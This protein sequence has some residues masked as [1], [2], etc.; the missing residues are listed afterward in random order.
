MAQTAGTRPAVPQR[1]P[2]RDPAAQVARPADL[3]Q[4]PA[5]LG[6]LRDPGDPAHPQLGGLAYLTL[7][8][9]IGLAVAVLLTV[10]VVS[11]RQVVQAYPERRWLLRGGIH[12]PGQLRRAR[13]GRGADGRLHHDRR[14]LGRLRRG[15]HHLRRPPA[16]RLPI[17]LDIGFILLLTAMNL[18]GIRESG[19]AFA[20]PTYLFIGGV[21]LMIVLGFGRLVAGHAPVAESA[22]YGVRPEQVGLTGLALVFLL[23]R[24]FS[25]G[26]T[27]LTGVEA[28]S[29]G[30]PAFRK[31]KSANAARTM[32]A[33]GA[34]AV[35]MFGGITALAHD[36]QGPDRREH[37]RPHRL[38]RQLRHRPAAHRDQPDRRGGL[39]W[40]PRVAVLL[41]A[42]HHRADPDPGGQ[43]RVQRV[44]AAGLDPRP[45]PLPAPPAAHPRRPARVLQRHHRAR[46]GRRDPDLRVRRLDDP[47]DPAL[48]PRRVHVVH[49]LPSGH[50]PAL[51][52]RAGHRDRRPAAPVDPAF[53][54][55]QRPRRG[56]HRDRPGR[57]A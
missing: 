6:R 38:P 21:M 14:G 45:G 16:Q 36:H 3:R 22:G 55:D 5:V 49:A 34:I 26:C 20:I 11:Y 18:R 19:R 4:R 2:R 47:A 57:R 29:N 37:L 15:Q 25:S 1:H 51:E 54:A 40:R 50:G 7:A 31:P 24:S 43:H 12:E 35:V 41:P 33:M 39:R 56:A 52:P 32:T 46:A 42:G 48:H 17:A 44:P 53:P 23:L 10:V 27:A 9:W 13:R 28:I 30:V 8:P